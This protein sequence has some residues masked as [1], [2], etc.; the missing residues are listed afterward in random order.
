MP[1]E[2]TPAVNERIH[3]V[4][5]SRPNRPLSLGAGGLRRVY[6]VCRR[7]LPVMRLT[8]WNY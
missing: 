1:E 5:F 8:F 6:T 4:V 7:A 3:G 2:A